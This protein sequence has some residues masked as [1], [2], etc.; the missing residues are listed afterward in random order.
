MNHSTEYILRILK[1]GR[2][3]GTGFLASTDLVVT[4]AHV[5]AKEE[6]VQVQFAGRTEVLSASLIPEYYQEPDKGDVAFLRLEKSPAGMIPPRFGAAVQSLSGNK[7]WAF[8]YPRV[9]AV[10]GAHALGEILGMVTENEQDLLQLRSKELRQGHSGAP[11]STKSVA[12]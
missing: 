10:E 9:G 3:I 2:T 4:C 1:N 11:V 7:I 6:A 8:G 5:V 12:R